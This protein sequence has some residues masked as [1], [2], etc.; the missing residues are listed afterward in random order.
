MVSKIIICKSVQDREP[1]GEGKEFSSV[2]RLYCWTSVNPKSVP[3]TIQ[4]VWQKGGKTVSTVPLTVKYSPSRTWSTFAV[5]PGNWKV[6]VLSEKD[7]VLSSAEF[8]VK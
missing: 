2:T 1:M 6:E 5:T 7:E 8:T 3:S 4:H